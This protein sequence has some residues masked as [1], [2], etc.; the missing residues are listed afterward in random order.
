MVDSEYFTDDELKC[1]CGC[2]RVE[3]N[4]YFINKLNALRHTLNFPFKVTSGFRCPEYNYKLS[5]SRTGPH[6]HGRAVDITVSGEQAFKLIQYASSF[7]MLGIGVKQSGP[8]EQR[9]VHLDDMTEKEGF[10]RPTIWSY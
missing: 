10:P 9:F 7:Q 5:K 6:T 1:R 2:N 4:T 8:I 3:M